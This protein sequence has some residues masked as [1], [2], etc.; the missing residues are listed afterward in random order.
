MKSC[1]YHDGLWEKDVYVFDTEKIWYSKASRSRDCSGKKTKQKHIGQHTVQCWNMIIMKL[2]RQVGGQSCRSYT[3]CWEIHILLKIQWGV[4]S[5]F[6]EENGTVIPEISWYLCGE[7]IVR[8]WS[9]S[10]R[11]FKSYRNLDENK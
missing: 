6:T 9:G 4:I 2:E 5:I 7:Q 8:P 10:R 1:C 3:L 11:R